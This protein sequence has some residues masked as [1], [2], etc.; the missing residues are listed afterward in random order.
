MHV[1]SDPD[2]RFPPISMFLELNFRPTNYTV[3]FLPH[4]TVN[5]INVKFAALAIV[6]QRRSEVRVVCSFTDELTYTF[7]QSLYGGQ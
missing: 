7:M 5:S 1:A 3:F 6:S 2:S 4:T